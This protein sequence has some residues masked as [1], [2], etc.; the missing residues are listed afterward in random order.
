MLDSAEA[1][2]RLLGAL[3][4]QLSRAGHHYELI[5]IGG[6]ALLALG[7]VSRSTRDVDVVALMGTD[8]VDEALPLPAPLIAARARVARD[9]EVPEDW[10]NAEAAR[11][12]LRLG[13]RKDSRT[14]F[15]GARTDRRLPFTTPRDSTRSTSSCTPRWTAAAGSTSPTCA[16]SSRP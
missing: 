15:G 7:L 5:V 6:S 9:F 10:L 11:D 1:T 8:G 13:F 12:M 14:G 2:D 16:H 4:E 3:G